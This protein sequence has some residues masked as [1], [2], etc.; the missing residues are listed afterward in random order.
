M[1][2]ADVSAFYTPV[3]GGVRTYVD[4]K[5][6]YAEQA[7]IDLAVIVPGADD[8][9]EERGRHARLIRIASPHLIFDRR[10]RYFA[11]PAAVHAALD[12]FA[13]DFVEASS[14]WRTASIVADWAGTA[15]RAL[16]M[17]ADPLAAYAYRWFGNVARRDTIDRGFEWYWAHL[18]RAA[19]RY[20]LIVSANSGLTARLTAGG[21]RRAATI[22]FGVDPNVFSAR[23]RNEAVRRELLASCGLGDAALLLVGVGRQSPEKR[24][25]TVIEAAG[26]AGLQCRVGLVLV[27]EG[28]DH[29]KLVRQIGSNPH[30]RMVRPT[31]SREEMAILLASADALIH[32]CEAETFGLVAAEAVASGLPLIVPDEGG[33]ADQGCAD[34]AEFYRAGDVAAAAAAIARLAGRD[35]AALRAAAA[36]AAMQVRTLDDHFDELFMR[37]R[38]LSARPAL[39]A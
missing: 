23:L 1:R 27:G 13:P 19:S 17:H 29:A 10:Y 24:W 33:A 3:G 25:G 28:R 2:V 15:P 22:A 21:I 20:D 34:R 18:R 16:V 11:S 12:A 14:P 4:R 31:R 32:G 30:V 7:G 36:C 9:I 35:R 38:Q 5:L 39:L 37:Y 8:G 6:A 26:V